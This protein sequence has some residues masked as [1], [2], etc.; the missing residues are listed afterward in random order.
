MFGFNSVRRP[1]DDPGFASFLVIASAAI[2]GLWAGEVVFATKYGL[3]I[4]AGQQ[5]PWWYSLFFVVGAV[6]VLVRS[7]GRLFRTGVILFATVAFDSIRRRILRGW[8]AG[9]MAM[10]P[11]HQLHRFSCA[12][13]GQI[14]DA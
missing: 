13:S 5:R 6:A 3:R 2:L 9:G 4:S 10:G 11:N 14:P 7:E 12:Q 1:A 8:M